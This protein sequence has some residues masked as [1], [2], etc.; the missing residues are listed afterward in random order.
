MR[1]EIQKICQSCKEVLH[2]DTCVLSDSYY[3][4]S[5]PLCVIDSVF[6]IGVKYTSTQNAV[7]NYCRYFSLRE[8]NLNR[9]AAGD[10]HTI[11]ELIE[12]IEKIGI[13]AC[14]DRVVCNH[15]RTSSR[16]GILKVEAVLRFA[17]VLQK[18]GI[19]RLRDLRAST[20]P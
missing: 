1:A 4:D 14:A 16:N 18:Y 8:Y 7:R 10:Q 11:T 19:E 12:H 6:S 13:Q 17:K 15:Q 9:D 3:Y 5:L 2:L 20:L